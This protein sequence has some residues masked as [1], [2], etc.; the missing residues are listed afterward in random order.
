M[1]GFSF[2]GHDNDTYFFYDRTD[3]QRCAAC[4]HLL[5][6]WQEDISM[7]KVVRRSLDVSCSYDGVTVVSSRFRKLYESAGLHGL[8]FTPLPD[9]FFAVRP[10]DEVAFDPV[11]RKTRFLRLCPVC[12]L[13][14]EVIGA[15]P[16]FLKEG[17]T[18]PDLGFVRTDLEFG[19]YIGSPSA[20]TNYDT[21]SPVILCGPGA[22]AVLR[23]GA[24]QGLVLEPIQEPGGPAV[25]EEIYDI[26]DEREIG[27][28]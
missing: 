25:T 20:K 11:R 21:K 9:Q 14:K 2:G 6:K 5:N 26:T 13:Y 10:T 18:I 1:I 4:G 17:T 15:R 12:G 27:D 7:I 19:S 3:V 8:V 28:E 23:E 22:A 24:F 16:A